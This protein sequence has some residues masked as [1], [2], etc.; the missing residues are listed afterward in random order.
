MT[1]GRSIVGVCIAM[2]AGLAALAVVKPLDFGSDRWQP[3]EPKH[4]ARLPALET[5]APSITITDAAVLG[6]QDKVYRF[7]F[8]VID[9]LKFSNALSAA[10][11]SEEKETKNVIVGFRENLKSV[12][13]MPSWWAGLLDG[14]HDVAKVYSGATQPAREV[15]LIS[16]DDRWFGQVVEY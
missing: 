14:N 11:L 16:I 4:L 15:T 12:P 8:R 9:Q 5:I 7:R 1:L 3:L 6:F 2:A 13:A 10:G